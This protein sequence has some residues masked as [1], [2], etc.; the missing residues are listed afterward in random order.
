MYQGYGRTA[1]INAV[2]RGEDKCAELLVAGGA[3]VNIQDTNGFTALI[4]AAHRGQDKC[5]EILIAAG[6]DVNIQDKEGCTALM[7]AVQT[8]HITSVNILITA[9]ADVN[10]AEK[11]GSTFSDAFLCNITWFRNYDLL[12]LLL[13]LLAAVAE[14]KITT[15]PFRRPI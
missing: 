6:A 11:E 15:Y 4:W 3:D 9:G 13:D 12:T 10:I 5:A 14:N 1:L 2:S 8:G 7:R